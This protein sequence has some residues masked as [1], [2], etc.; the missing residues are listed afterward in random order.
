MEKKHKQFRQ[1]V[2]VFVGL[3]VLTALE[4]AIAVLTGIYFL[5]VLTALLKAGLVAWYY[6]HIRKVFT[7]SGE[8]E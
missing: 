6:M 8:H 1:G 7:T 2:M 5:L 3:A 4:F